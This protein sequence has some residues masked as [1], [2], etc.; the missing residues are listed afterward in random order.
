MNIVSIFSRAGLAG[1]IAMTA[2]A[3]GPSVASA[4]SRTY[5]GAQGYDYDPCRRDTVGRSTTGGIVGALAGAAIG[6]NVAGRGVRKEGAVL[7]ALAGAAVGAGIGKSSAACNPAPGQAYDTGNRDY[8]DARYPG[9]RQ[10]DRYNYSY[11]SAGYYGGDRYSNP[12]YGYRPQ[13]RRVVVVKQYDSPP[14]SQYN[15]YPSAPPAGNAGTC[16]LAESPIYLP[17]GRVQQRFVRVCQDA[18]GRYQV[19]D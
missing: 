6:S 9:N 1:L 12:D 8:G 15:R 13:E 17:D 2:V 3:A 19:V 7:G 5:Y 4:Q 10:D 16:T 14:A 11:G 18:N